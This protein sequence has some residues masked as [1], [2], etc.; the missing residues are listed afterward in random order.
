MGTLLSII[1]FFIFSMGCKEYSTLCVIDALL[2]SIN[3][4]GYYDKYLNV[5]EISGGFRKLLC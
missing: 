2:Y 5:I 3:L 1:V 4:K